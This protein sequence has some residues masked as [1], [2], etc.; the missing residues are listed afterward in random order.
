MSHI[1]E[2]RRI[3]SNLLINVSRDVVMDS[4]DSNATPEFEEQV[5]HAI[6]EI[7]F[8]LEEEAAEVG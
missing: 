8:D 6:R 7:G 4:L 1:D 3:A 2:A 5:Y